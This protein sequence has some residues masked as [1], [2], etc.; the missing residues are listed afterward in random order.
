MRSPSPCADPASFVEAVANVKNLG[1]AQ[2]LRE[3][4]G[5]HGVYANELDIEW[6][7]VEGGTTQ[8]LPDKGSALGLGELGW[9]N[10]LP[11]TTFPRIDTLLVIAT[12][13]PANLSGLTTQEVAMRSATRSKGSSGLEQ[14]LGQL[15]TG[16]TREV[17][18]ATAIDGHFAK[19]LTYLLHP[20]DGK[21]TS[22][23]FRVD[24][25]PGAK[26]SSRAAAAWRAPASKAAIRKRAS[27]EPTISRSRSWSPNHQFQHH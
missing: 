5:E 13:K 9:P 27:I 19:Q 17:G 1:V 23:D 7:V 10:G 3:L 20:R 6:G 24:D 8:P 12:V 4:E 11:T 21:M 18:G 14:L 15:Q 26:G 2:A 22:P 16:V 25:A